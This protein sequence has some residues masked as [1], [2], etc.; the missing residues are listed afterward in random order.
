MKHRPSA[1][2]LETLRALYGFGVLLLDG[3]YASESTVAAAHALGLTVVAWDVA[4][5]R[6]DALLEMGVDGLVC[7]EPVH[8][9][10]E[11]GRSRR[12]VVGGRAASASRAGSSRP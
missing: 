10:G 6:R 9:R 3:W 1:H 5:E 7:A 2:A 8:V 12:R 11:N 4:D